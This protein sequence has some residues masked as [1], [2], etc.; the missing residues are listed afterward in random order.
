MRPL[1]SG[2]ISFGL[3]NVPVKLYSAS[4]E[5]ALSFRMLEKKTLSP[6]SYKKVIKG[7]DTEVEQKDIVKGY[8]CGDG[9]YVVL[10]P[11]DFKRANP[12]KTELLDILGFVEEGEIDTKLFEKPYFIEPAAKAKKAYALLRDALKKSGKVGI[13]R[14]VIH[15]KEHIGIIKCENRMLMLIQLRFAD[16]LRTA[17]ELEIPGSADYAKKELDLAVSLIDNLTE[18]D[19]DIKEYKDTYADELKKVI[20]AKG[21]GDLKS[22]SAPSEAPATNVGDILEMLRKSLEETAPAR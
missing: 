18:E 3:V 7:T 6:I 9:T 19:F 17:E 4:E 8:A 22:V 11:A 16:E 15:E 2:S 12:K 13:A 14:Y 20:K 21:K 5:R 10:T 1:W